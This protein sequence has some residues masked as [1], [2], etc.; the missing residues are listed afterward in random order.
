MLYALP[1]LVAEPIFYIQSFPVTNAYINSTIA[2]VLFLIAGFLLR[3]K[4]AMIPRG[5]QNFSEAVIEFMLSYIDQVTHDRKKSLKFFPVV[6]G[7]F[8]F[9]LV[10]NWLGLIPG[11]G[12]IGRYLLMH[13]EIELIPLLR[14]ANSDL[15]MTVAMAVF[16]VVLSHI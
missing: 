16:A 1:P 15:N 2:V 14:P 8:L 10:S 12:S 7:L 5:F 3:K 4:T 11:T 6:G 9:I 13:G